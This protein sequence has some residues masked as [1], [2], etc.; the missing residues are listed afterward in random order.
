M[1]TT[2]DVDN[3][4]DNHVNN[5]KLYYSPSIQIFFFF[6]VIVIGQEKMER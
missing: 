2:R 5:N 3:K 1:M 6:I 4:S